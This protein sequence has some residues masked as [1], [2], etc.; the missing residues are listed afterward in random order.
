MEKLKTG[1]SSSDE[2]PLDTRT[3]EALGE[4]LLAASKNKD[5]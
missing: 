5:K 2:T 4:L 1:K 3:L